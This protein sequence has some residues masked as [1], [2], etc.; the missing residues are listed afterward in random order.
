MKKSVFLTIILVAGLMLVSGCS[1]STDKTA[2][3]S[4]PAVPS[5]PGMMVLPPDEPDNTVPPAPTPD[6]GTASSGE[7][8]CGI[9]S[10]HG[11]DITCGPDVPEVCN[12]I[13]QL[14]DFCRQY[15]VCEVFN[16]ECQMVPNDKFDQCVACVN[17][18]ED[19]SGEQAF[20]CEDDCRNAMK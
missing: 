1:K 17:E 4:A 11:Y 8:K 12:E 5:K 2:D 14:G 3:D 9:E 16:G 20:S 18:C 19:L 7:E 15:A 6:Q 13:Y 10:C